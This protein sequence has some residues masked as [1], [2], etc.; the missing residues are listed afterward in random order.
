[1][2]REYNQVLGVI[3]R[4]VQ[5][6]GVYVRNTNPK[7]TGGHIGLHQEVVYNRMAPDYQYSDNHDRNIDP[8]PTHVNRYHEAVRWF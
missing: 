1:M 5:V 3:G 8:D 6:L 7:G 4:G 2:N